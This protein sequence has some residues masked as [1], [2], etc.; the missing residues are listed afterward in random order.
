MRA[1]ITLIISLLLLYGCGSS[2]VRPGS[3]PE[4][5][6]TRAQLLLDE[7]SYQQ[8]AAEY[9]RLAAQSPGNAGRYQLQAAHAY[10]QAN[11]FELATELLDGLQ[12]QPSDQ[13]ARFHQSVLRA[14][15]Q[16]AERQPANA[17]SLLNVEMPAD[18][19]TDLVIMML[20][21]RAEVYELQDKFADA[22]MERIRLS[23]YLVHPVQVETNTLKIWNHLININAE[24]LIK[25]R[26]SGIDNVAPWI[27]LATIS[28]SLMSRKD[29]LKQAIATWTANYPRHPAGRYIT[30]QIIAMSEKFNTRPAH[31][32]LLLPLTGMFERYSERIRDGF[33]AA[34]FNDTSYKPVVSIYNA[35]ASNINSVYQTAVEN[36]AEFIV[37]PLEK[38]AVRILAEQESLPVRT[39]ALNQI[40]SGDLSPEYSERSRE[41]LDLIQ[42]GLPPEDEAR[43]VARRG[44]SEG[45]TRALVITSSDEFGDRVYRAF[46]QEW[47]ASGGTTLEH[48]RY[49]PQTGDFIAPVKE[50]LNIDGSEA[51][52][53][54]LR[55]RLGRSIIATSRVRQDPD[56]IFMVASNL[57]ARQIV[58][59]LRFFRA[60]SIPIYTVSLVYTG[61]PMP[62]TDNDLNGVEFVDMPWLLKQGQSAS[63]LHS[64][65]QDGWQI[66]ASV[67]PR[68]YAFG[69][70]AYQLITRIGELA[71]NPVYSYPGETGDL[72]MDQIGLIHRNLPWARFTNGSPQR[73]DVGST[74]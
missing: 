39:L 72:Y 7:G 27:E 47:A 68:Y 23:Y 59:H 18:T 24:E 31:I 46:T 11:R 25:I 22:A 12:L 71:L 51:R 30:P 48:V 10:I 32:A 33:L 19:R 66:T 2:D 40:D 74:D 58:P 8:A 73:I 63:S 28:D 45:Y 49:Y 14:Y 37:G 62:Q 57:T 16:L 53:N 54:L 4:A 60:E 5:P 35:D 52:I 41:L 44:L 15:I 64:Q 42:F 43:Q 61:N 67:F 1:F 20:Q 34:W 70:D 38:D 65:I 36:G 26:T 50:L 29:Q 21:I 69:I 9:V 56:F 6:E 3:T 17:L 13:A 55:Q